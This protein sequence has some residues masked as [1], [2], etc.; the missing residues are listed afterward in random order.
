MFPKMCKA[1]KPTHKKQIDLLRKIRS[2]TPYRAFVA[3]GIRYD[4]ISDDKVHGYA[5]YLKKL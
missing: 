1:L 5:E 2:L 4:L 3:S